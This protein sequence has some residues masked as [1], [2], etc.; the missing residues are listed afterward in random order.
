MF[1]TLF[2]GNNYRFITFFL[3]NNYRFITL[4]LGNMFFSKSFKIRIHLMETI[5][6][7]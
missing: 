3:G 5:T 6:L 2:L 4:F 7:S 1:V